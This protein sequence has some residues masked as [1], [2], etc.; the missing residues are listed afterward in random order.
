M[1]LRESVLAQRFATILVSCIERTEA[2]KGF[3]SSMLLTR[4]PGQEMRRRRVFGFACC[5]RGHKVSVP[6]R[7]SCAVMLL[8]LHEVQRA[9]NC[10]I[11]EKE[12]CS[13]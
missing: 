7:C 3:V 11:N 13:M 4:A 5:C 10:V 8:Y 2:P 6:S 12:S 1:L 9:S